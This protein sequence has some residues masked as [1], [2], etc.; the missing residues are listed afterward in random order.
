MN[1][2]LCLI[3]VGLICLG[4][5]SAGDFVVRNES[6]SSDI[7]FI[8]NGTTGNTNITGTS[9]FSYL[10]S[11]ADRIL[12]IFATDVDVSNNLSVGGNFSV[13]TNTFFV[14]TTNGNV[15]IGTT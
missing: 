11:L 2:L 14:D 1:K 7:Y 3:F 12:G 10:G 6:D 8:V 5:V 15:G 9:F 4:L 13:N